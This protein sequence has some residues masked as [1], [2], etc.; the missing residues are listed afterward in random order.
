MPKIDFA[1]LADA[2]QAEP[3][4]QKFYVLGGGIDSIGVPTFPVVYPQISLVLRL[5]VHP[6]EADRAHTL[7][8]RLMDADG[9]ELAN[10]KGSFSGTHAQP[11]REMG[12]PLV[13]NMVNIQFQAAGDYSLEV[14][15]NNQHGKSLPLRVSQMQA[16]SD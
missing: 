11:G 3:A 9:G 12:V 4:S 15:I 8:I 1:F 6:A 10:I 5:L 7:E 2:A 14:L 13:V 16:P